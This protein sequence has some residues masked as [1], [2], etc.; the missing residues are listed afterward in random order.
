MSAKKQEVEDNTLTYRMFA[1]LITVLSSM[2]ASNRLT[3]DLGDAAATRDLIRLRARSPSLRLL[4]LMG[5]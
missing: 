5:I 1:L 2:D 4:R 3:Q